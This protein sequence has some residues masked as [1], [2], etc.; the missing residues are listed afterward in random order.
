MEAEYKI[1]AVYFPH[2]SELELTWKNIQTGAEAWLTVKV[3]KEEGE[4]VSSVVPPCVY[5]SAHKGD[6]NGGSSTKKQS[7]PCPHFGT[8]TICNGTKI[9]VCYGDGKLPPC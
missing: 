5:V 4:R 8:E 9:D 7:V 6:R 2:P 1:S 3:S